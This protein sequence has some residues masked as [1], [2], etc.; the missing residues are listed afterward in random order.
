MS[1]FKTTKAKRSR[2]PLKID[3]QGTS[4]S[5]KTYTALR[6]AFAMRRNG[7][8][9]RIVVAD[10]ENESASLY[11]GVT[12]DGEKWSYDVCPIPPDKQNPS[13]Y[14]ECYNYL[15]SE[16]YDIIIIDSMS[17]AWAG[18]LQRVDE[19]AARSKSGDKFTTGWRQVTPE[20]EALFKTITGPK[21]HVITTTRVK[22][23]YDKVQGYGG[24]EG[25]GKVGT[26]S[27]Q[28]EGAEYEYDVVIRIN[29]EA[30]EHVAVVEKVRGCTAMDGKSAKCPGPDFWMPLFDWWK[31]ADEVPA[32]SASI[33]A[34]PT[35]PTPQPPKPQVQAESTIALRDSL[36]KQILDA[37]SE[38]EV[39][40]LMSGVAAQI[41]AG[42][43]NANEDAQY[44]RGA[45]MSKFIK[46]A[47]TLD[48]L[49]KHSEKIDVSERD[50]KIAS[51]VAERLRKLRDDRLAQLKPQE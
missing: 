37:E 35:L 7:I 2:R 25:W 19:L 3:I 41:Q 49:L 29:N 14:V 12:T 10:S 39:K 8:G 20:Q 44:I 13:G 31:S 40:N 16:G 28:R 18:A 42:Q 47:K 38:E 26:K 24:K 9:T 36:T 6:T 11:D 27:I 5:G 34:K 48:D 33:D 50:G 21:A 51:N 17:H 32:Q 22:T 23:E 43:L 45:A 15:V 30:G 1:V 46:L 4:G